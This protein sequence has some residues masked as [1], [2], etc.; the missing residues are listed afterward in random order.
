MF[1]AGYIVSAYLNR[2]RDSGSR[3]HGGSIE[4]MRTGFSPSL[5][6]WHHIVMEKNGNIGGNYRMYIDGKRVYFGV[7]GAGMDSKPLSWTDVDTGG[8]STLKIGS[9]RGGNNGSGYS[10]VKMRQ[11]RIYNRLLTDAEVAGSY[12]SGCGADPTDTTG[13]KLWCPMSE[14]SGDTVHDWSHY[15]QNGVL[16]VSSSGFE[17]T[18]EGI[19]ANSCTSGTAICSPGL[20]TTVAQSYRYG[21]NG[22]E[23][24]NDVYGE[25]DAYTADFWEYDPRLGRRWNVDPVV[26]PWE[27]PY[28][29]FDNNPV[30]YTDPDGADGSPNH[31]F[32]DKISKFFDNIKQWAKTGEWGM[33][34]WR[35]HTASGYHRKWGGLAGL[36][37]WN[38]KVGHYENASGTLVNNQS[39]P[40]GTVTD[41]YYNMKQIEAATGTTNFDKLRRVE[42]SGDHGSLSNPTYVTV[43]G[44]YGTNYIPIASSG[45]TG[46][47][48]LHPDG[49]THFE[50]STGIIPG[51]NPVLI[52]L[53]NI[54]AS[55]LPSTFVPG[56][57][58]R[59]D[60]VPL[61]GGVVLD[62]PAGAANQVPPIYSINPALSH[63]NMLRVHVWSMNNAY[64]VNLTVNVTVRTWRRLSGS[65]TS[66]LWKFIY[67]NTDIRQ[68]K[69]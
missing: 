18:Y 33:G 60:P 45:S 12:N 17:D 37:N 29:T 8:I 24:D 63:T 32:G 55:S 48:N 16:F 47:F 13:L 52:T 39:F 36:F 2:N 46:F 42:F 58:P 11:V 57:P 59:L 61:I 69:K 14:G 7:Y 68:I 67:G 4:A 35:K 23:K 21:H 44:L 20:Y 25:G 31:T 40:G 3:S 38:I 1:G 6:K 64:N 54:Y 22:M 56:G 53:W 50:G 26:K 10:N 9:H 62:D 43:D 28:A 51:L 15:A 27:S 65:Q 49:V 30:Y 5:K 34:R 19:N 41:R 66:L